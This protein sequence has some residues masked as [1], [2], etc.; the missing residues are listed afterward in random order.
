MSLERLERRGFKPVGLD[1]SKNRLPVVGSVLRTGYWALAGS[2]SGSYVYPD[3]LNKFSVSR[4]HLDD[5]SRWAKVDLDPEASWLDK[6]DIIKRFNRNAVVLGAGRM[7]LQELAVSV[8][9]LAQPAVAVRQNNNVSIGVLPVDYGIEDDQ[10]FGDNLLATVA[11]RPGLKTFEAGMGFVSYETG[12]F[13]PVQG[14]HLVTSSPIPCR[15]LPGKYP[16]TPLG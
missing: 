1:N 5:L 8:N 4:Q 12:R 11:L 13:T 14:I 9:A 3:W 2:G 7:A 16:G 10:R 15:E 6:F